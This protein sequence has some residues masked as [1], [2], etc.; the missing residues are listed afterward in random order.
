MYANAVRGVEFQ[1]ELFEGRLLLLVRCA[2][3]PEPLRNRFDV[4]GEKYQLEMQVTTASS[5]PF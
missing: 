2:P 1:N 4:P 3:L 5:P